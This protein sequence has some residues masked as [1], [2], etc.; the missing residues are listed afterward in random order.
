[1]NYISVL[2]T[3]TYYRVVGLNM[4]TRTSIVFSTAKPADIVIGSTS[5]PDNYATNVYEVNIGG[6]TNSQSGIR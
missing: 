4:S 5:S 6:W 3:P 2:G 1:M